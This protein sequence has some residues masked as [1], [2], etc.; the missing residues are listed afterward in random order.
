MRGFS[1]A[2]NLYLKSQCDTD[3]IPVL[4]NTLNQLQVGK[5]TSKNKMLDLLFA[6]RW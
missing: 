2:I 4:V 6:P 1:F 3:F 5:N